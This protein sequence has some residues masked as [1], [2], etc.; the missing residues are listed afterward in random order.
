MKTVLGSTEPNLSVIKFCD[1]EGKKI[2]EINVRMDNMVGKIK[3][4]MIK[5]ITRTKMT[6]QK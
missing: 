5:M 2:G 1:R 6:I 4:I 3:D